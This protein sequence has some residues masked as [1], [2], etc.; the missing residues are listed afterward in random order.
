MPGMRG[1]A[2]HPFQTGV[3]RGTDHS[4][5]PGFKMGK[6]NAAE[7]GGDMCELWIVA[8]STSTRV[9]TSFL[10]EPSRWENLMSL[11]YPDETFD[12]V[13]HSDTLEHVPDAEKAISEIWRVLKKGGVSIFLVPIIRDGRRTLTRATQ[14]DK[15]EIKHHKPASYHGG[16]MQ[17][18]NQY[19]VF[20]EFG[21]DFTAIIQ[22][23]GFKVNMAESDQNKAA[24]TFIV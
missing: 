3:W 15:G 13:L 18:T 24:V 19:L 1:K 5:G 21:D 16:C 10:D 4:L 20:S 8:K 11:T 7:G 14:T 2:H 9:N 22:K 12:V 23:Q 17:Q 6:P